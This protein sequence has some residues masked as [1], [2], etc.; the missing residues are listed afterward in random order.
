MEK[1]LFFSGYCR[2]LDQ[3]RMVEAEIEDGKLLSGYG[4]DKKQ[5]EKKQTAP[6]VG[7]YSGKRRLS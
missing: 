7:K 3:S 2:A 6:H 4:I 1:E 5:I